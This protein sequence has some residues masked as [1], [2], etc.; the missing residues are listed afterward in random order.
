MMMI[1][2][3]KL[4]ELESE[5]Q[6]RLRILSDQKEAGVNFPHLMNKLS[7]L[8]RRLPIV[9]QENQSIEAEIQRS[10]VE[11]EQDKE[12]VRTGTGQG[13]NENWNRTRNR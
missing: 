1:S 3:A 9:E 7:M 8:R 6:E 2:E 4:K 5:Q 10:E 12:Q 13:T 11:L